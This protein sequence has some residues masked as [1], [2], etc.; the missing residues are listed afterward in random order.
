[1]TVPEQF[2]VRDS[3]RVGWFSVDNEIIDNHAAR[4][5]AYGVAVYSVLCWHAKYGNPEVRLSTRD[6][7]G[8]LGISHDRVRKSLLDLADAR[9][10]FQEVPMRPG[11]GLISTY[12]LLEVKET[13]RHASSLRVELDAVRP[14]NKEVKTKTETQTAPPPISSLFEES[15]TSKENARACETYRQQDYDERDLRKLGDA[16]REIN[17]R[18]RMGLGSGSTLGEKEIFEAACEI[19]GITVKRGL[20]VQKLGR[21]WPADVEASV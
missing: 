12:T 16:Y 20:E 8:T 4:I 10:I 5:G 2:T 14:C 7:A 21:Q 1:M 18:L 3:R 19:A 15:F 9:L 6:I 17:S 11:P 13:G